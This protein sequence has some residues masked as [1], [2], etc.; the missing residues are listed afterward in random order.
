MRFVGEAAAGARTAAGTMPEDVRDLT[1]RALY[2][3]YGNHRPENELLG[4]ALVV[5]F[6][7]CGGSLAEVH[8]TKRGHFMPKMSSRISLPGS[9]WLLPRDVPLFDFSQRKLR[10]YVE[11]TDY[12]SDDDPLFKSAT[13]EAMTS[14]LCC[15]LFSRLGERIELDGGKVPSILRSAFVRW[16]EAC[17]T[18]RVRLYLIGKKKHV[19]VSR[20]GEAAPAFAE[21]KEQMFDAHPLARLH[22]YDLN[23]P[24]PVRR[25]FPNPHFPTL[26]RDARSDLASRNRLKIAGLP[27]EARRAIA[28]AVA[29]GKSKQE[30]ADHFGVDLSTVKNQLK[31]ASPPTGPKPSHPSYVRTLRQLAETTAD[32][33]PRKL[34]AMVNAKYGSDRGVETIRQTAKAVGIALARQPKTSKWRDIRPTLLAMMTAGA[35]LSRPEIRTKL[36]E[37]GF[38]VTDIALRDALRTLKLSHLVRLE[39]KGVDKSP[40]LRFEKAWPAIREAMLADPTVPDT[41]INRII[42]DKAGHGIE[43]PILKRLL[44]ERTDLPP[45]TGVEGRSRAGSRP[46][47]DAFEKAWPDLRRRLVKDP[48]LTNADLVRIVHALTGRKMKT[49]R[50]VILLAGRDDVPPRSDS[51]SRSVAAL[52]KFRAMRPASI[53]PGI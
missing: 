27:D 51:A 3:T 34:A 38:E 20:A 37:Q 39:R 30:T 48:G 31:G 16:M 4:P 2:V 13:G 17:A 8:K 12:A 32:L 11:E 25:A 42:E 15:A 18:D 50:M 24:G 46:S 14:S 22:R 28:A 45:R 6:A 19:G 53:S 9:G 33:T 10:A 23:A 35:P 5:F 47:R 49:G 43:P 1:E 52:A 29:S 44:S 36:A 41:K 40:A 7:C 21:T 26:S